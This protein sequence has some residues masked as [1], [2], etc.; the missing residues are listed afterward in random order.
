[1]EKQLEKKP[2]ACEISR[3]KVAILMCTYNGERFIREQLESFF[4]QTHDNWELWISD[5]GSS[6][7]TLAIIKEYENRGKKITVVE[8]PRQGFAANFLT[9]T[10]REKVKADYYAWSDQDDVWLPEKLTA[11]LKKLYKTGESLP[12]LY[13]GRTALMDEQGKHIGYSPLFKKP[14][15]FKNALCQNAVGGNTALFN[16]AARILLSKENIPSVSSHDWWLY[17]LV[18]GS[19]GKIIYDKQAFLNYRQ[20]ANNI[21]G[22][23]LGFFSRL[24]RAYYLLTGD[25]QSRIRQNLFSLSARCDVLTPENGK[26]FVCLKQMIKNNPN[27]L[28]KPWKLRQLK[29]YRQTQLHNL[30]LFFA[31]LFKKYP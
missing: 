1:M 17:L 12:A 21:S 16:N 20:H 14:L 11:A 10:R 5:D 19:G 4:M 18:S 28:Q 31:F 15:T 6:D 3:L 13:C 25:F 30:I 22:A 8:G 9:L 23:R 7:Q 2:D 29:I 26:I 24:E 27:L